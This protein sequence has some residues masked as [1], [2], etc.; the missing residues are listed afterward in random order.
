MYDILLQILPPATSPIASNMNFEEYSSPLSHLRFSA[1]YFSKLVFGE[2]IELQYPTIAPPGALTSQNFS[3]EEPGDVAATTVSP[4]DVIP[5]I[6]D[7]LPT[8]L[9]KNRMSV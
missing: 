7:L 2:T 6:Y 1:N 9:L 5:N 3:T 4:L 8:T